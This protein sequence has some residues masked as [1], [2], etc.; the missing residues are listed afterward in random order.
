[1]PFILSNWKIIAFGAMVFFLVFAPIL[2]LDNHNKKLIAE[3]NKKASIACDVIVQSMLI[4]AEKERRAYIKRKDLI[5]ANRPSRSDVVDI[6]R[7]G[8]F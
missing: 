3:T 1:M 7:K 5:S 8:E 6:L 2:W 4:K